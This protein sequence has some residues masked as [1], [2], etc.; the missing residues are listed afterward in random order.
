MSTE[1]G[2]YLISTHRLYPGWRRWAGGV[3]EL[4]DVSGEVTFETARG[5]AFVFPFVGC[6]VSGELADSREYLLGNPD[7]R[8]RSRPLPEPPYKGTPTAHRRF[9]S[10]NTGG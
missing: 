5:V 4:P 7:A 8:A 2:N 3:E 10:F 1:A 6:A 9:S